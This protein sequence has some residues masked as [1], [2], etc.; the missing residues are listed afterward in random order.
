MFLQIFSHLR[1]PRT[2]FPNYLMISPSGKGNVLKNIWK[3]SHLRIS[4]K[5][6]CKYVFKNI[7]KFSQFKN[8]EEICSKIFGIWRKCFQKYLEIFPSGNLGQSSYQPAQSSIKPSLSLLSHFSQ[9]QNKYFNFLV[10]NIKISK[11]KT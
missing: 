9:F 10:I 4:R 7:R 11:Y 5:C 3:Y 1:I 6:F 8:I 2:Y